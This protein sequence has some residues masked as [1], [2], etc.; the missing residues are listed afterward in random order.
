MLI[1]QNPQV[2]FIISK[3]TEF[4]GQ[5]NQGCQQTG[6]IVK[7]HVEKYTVIKAINLESK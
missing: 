7:Q 5:N 6:H 1:W 2:T 3:L 4:I